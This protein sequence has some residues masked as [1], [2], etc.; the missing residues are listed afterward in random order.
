MP[1]PAL[2]K[3]YC[4]RVNIPTTSHSTAAIA[5]RNIVWLL[6]A[7]LKDEVTS[8][9]LTGSRHPNS[10]WTCVGSSDGVTAALDGVD[11]WGTAVFDNTKIVSATA[12]SPHSWIILQNSTLGYQLLLDF[13]SSNQDYL[14]IA[15]TP[16]TTPWVLAGTATHSPPI[17]SKS[18]ATSS[19]NVD[20]TG[21]SF[22]LSSNAAT[23]QYGTITIDE[24][25]QFNFFVH[26]AGIGVSV[27]GLCVTK[28]DDAPVEDQQKLFFWAAFVSNIE[29]YWPNTYSS[30][31]LGALSPFNGTTQSTASETQSAVGQI[32]VNMGNGVLIDAI[33]LK[34]WYWPVRTWFLSPIVYR[35]TVPDIYEV[36]HHGYGS[37][38]PSV[39]SPTHIKLGRYVLPYV[40]P[41][42][43]IMG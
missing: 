10:V 23:T 4:T 35:G 14:R 7:A 22:F 28:L 37:L 18:I 41:T 19:S 1:L 6:K 16:S 20:S 8:G 21:S 9:T 26:R 39:S 11:R 36:A 43:P 17:T 25:G 31:N 24:T 42:S 2:S 12:A 40:S 15:M 3:T 32:L 30:Y 5:G 38:S 34:A 27:G 29:P 13:N 33:A